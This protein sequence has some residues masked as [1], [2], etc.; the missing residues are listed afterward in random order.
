V[1]VTLSFSRDSGSTWTSFI[2]LM[3]DG[4]GSYSTNWVPQYPGSYRVES[5][6][7]GNN[8]F[9]GSTSPPTSLTVTGSVSPNPTVLLTSPG[10]ASIGQT[11]TMLITVFNPTSAPLNANVT[12]QITGPNSYVLFDVVQLTVSPSSQGAKYYDW[13][14]PNQSG[15][16]MVTVGLLPT[17]GAY[18]S[19]T[20]QVV[21]QAPRRAV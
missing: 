9:A 15:S 17:G 2:T 21:S 6:W 14:V 12:I 13:T 20:I 1:Q 11:V 10:A 8:Q 19:T 5:S 16:Y 3:T 4:T 7:S 18:D